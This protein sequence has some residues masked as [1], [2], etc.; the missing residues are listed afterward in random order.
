MH[1][2][3]EAKIA[4]YRDLLTKYQHLSSVALSPI[5]GASLNTINYYRRL[6]DLPWTAIVSC[7]CGCGRTFQAKGCQKFAPECGRRIAKERRAELRKEEYHRGPI[8]FEARA[9]NGRVIPCLACG[10]KFLSTGKGNRICDPCKMSAEFSGGLHVHGFG[11][12][13]SR[14]LEG[15]A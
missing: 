1:P 12:L 6:L 10:H 2:P 15:A 3:D 14:R 7:A 8:H 11:R 5:I 13:G 9:V 4:Y